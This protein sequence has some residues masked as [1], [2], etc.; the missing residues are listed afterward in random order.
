M[1]LAMPS[2]IG[3][4]VLAS[5]R[6]LNVMR[7]FN[8]TDEQERA[9][10]HEA[11][12]G[13]CSYFTTVLGPGYNIFHYNHFHVDLAMH[14]STSRGPRRYCKPVPQTS[15]PEPPVKDN[16]P[17]PPPIEEEMDIARAPVPQ[18]GYGAGPATVVASV[19]L[20][21]ALP[22]TPRRIR[23]DPSRAVASTAV[24]TA[25]GN[26]RAQRGGVKPAVVDAPLITFSDAESVDGEQ[27]E[28]TRRSAAFASQPS[29]RRTIR[30]AAAAEASQP[31]EA[32]DPPPVATEE[33]DS[34]PAPARQRDRGR[35]S[36]PEGTAGDWDLTSSVRR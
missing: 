35:P 17:D 13:A 29:S 28:T 8:G 32:E 7:G 18:S 20:S 3:G 27:P 19:P 21:P 25:E 6:E 9:F 31:A 33:P 1:P 12:A 4:F 26:E 22:Y 34:A 14:G 10:L 30:P 15:L 23:V 2:N 36:D 5:G 11:H 16:L 24:V